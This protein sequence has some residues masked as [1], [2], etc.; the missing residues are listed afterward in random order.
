L[1]Q[2]LSFSVVLNQL[3]SLLSE[4]FG[5]FGFPSLTEEGYLNKCAAWIKQHN[6]QVKPTGKGVRL[7][8]CQLPVKSPWLNAI[9][10]KWIHAKR[11]IIE[12]QRQL[13]AQEVKTRVCDYF[14]YSLLEPLAKKVS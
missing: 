9:E 7:I 13:T 10:P 14:G 1:E 6:A 2:L 8:V 3:K 5:Y 4:H 11:A 12:P